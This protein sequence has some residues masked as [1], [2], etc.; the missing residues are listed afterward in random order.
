[1]LTPPAG[2]KVE[3]L[4]VSASISGQV[5]VTFD[6]GSAA[7]FLSVDRALCNAGDLTQ[8]MKVS[9]DFGK[10]SLAHDSYSGTNVKVR[11][12][13]RVRLIR[14]QYSA[15]IVQEFPFFVR[16]F[17]PAPPI[18]SNIKMEGMSTFY[19]SPSIVQH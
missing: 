7:D 17:S 12:C 10:A 9:F 5:D 6:R 19:F 3:H 13:V 2:K 1:M 8:A 14:G 18:N 16:N 4:G 15:D 11:Y